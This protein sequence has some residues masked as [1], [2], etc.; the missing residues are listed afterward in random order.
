MIKFLKEKF[1]VVLLL[2]VI[3]TFSSLF[4]TSDKV[5]NQEDLKSVDL[6]WPINFISQNPA[7]SLTPP[8]SW[9]PK[10]MSFMTFREYPTSFSFILFFLDV[11]F[12]FAVIFAVVFTA[13]KLYPNSKILYYSFSTNVIVGFI[14]FGIFLFIFSFMFL[15][16][17]EK[18]KKG[19]DVPSE[20][21]E[22]KI[23]DMPFLSGK[24]EENKIRR[25]IIEAGYC[26]VSSDCKVVPAKCPFDCFAAVNKN[27]ANRIEDMINNYQSFCIYGC[28][29]IK[30]VD[31]VDNRCQIL[32]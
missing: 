28:I 27:E 3:F 19:V 17:Q 12:S 10:E 15:I 7:F 29:E 30:G 16:F 21:I 9:F 24:I 8:N 14:I 26:E 23:Q 25:E 6:G 11:I 20:V 22:R 32:K 1:F 31:C 13:F 4:W 2:S 18:L 5:Y